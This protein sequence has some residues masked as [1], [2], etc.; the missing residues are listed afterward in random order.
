MNQTDKIFI[1][2]EYG[3]TK[4]IISSD[5]VKMNNQIEASH[6][7]SDEDEEFHHYFEHDE[8]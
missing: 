3:L 1:Y 7:P 4:D 5:N 2:R 8:Y 6:R